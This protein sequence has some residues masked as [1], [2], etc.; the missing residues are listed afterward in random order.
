MRNGRAPENSKGK[1]SMHRFDTGAIKVG[2]TYKIDGNNIIAAHAGYETRA[3]LFEYSYVSPRIKDDAIDGLTTS[4]IVSGDI[5]YIWNYRRFRGSI[6]GFWTEM[7]DLTER[8]SFY[9]DQYSTFMNYVL[10][11]IHKRHA[12]VGDRRSLQDHPLDHRQRCS[13]FRQLP[14]QEPSD[15]NA[16]IRANGAARH[17][18]GRY[19]TLR[20]SASAAHLRRPST[21]VSTTPRSPVVGSSI[22]NV[23]GMDNAYTVFR[24]CAATK[25]HLGRASTSRH[26]SF[27][28]ARWSSSPSRRS[29]TTPSCSTPR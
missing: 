14:L 2:A 7:Y 9:D 24:R 8:T 5:A 21:S 28:R 26:S 10:K 11:G 25:S 6:T 20:T 12:G 27:S 23:I 19:A 1:G 17:H 13:N 3:P 4:R 18:S 15:R 29:S 22:F 16:L